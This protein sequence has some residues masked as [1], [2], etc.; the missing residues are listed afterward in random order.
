MLWLDYIE[1]MAKYDED[2]AQASAEEQAKKRRFFERALAAVGLH[3]AEGGKIW[4]AFREMEKH[5]LLDLE[6]SEVLFVACCY[7][8]YLNFL[9]YFC[10]HRIDS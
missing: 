2:S 8:M 1:F 4:K 7:P 10:H 9:L 5:L 6:G 3:Y